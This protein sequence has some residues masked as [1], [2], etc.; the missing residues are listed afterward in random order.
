MRNNF[1]ITQHGLRMAVWNLYLLVK[2]IS[3]LY[4]YEWKE[5]SVYRTEVPYVLAIFLEDSANRRPF[6]IDYFVKD[7]VLI[8]MSEVS[9]TH[10]FAVGR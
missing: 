7:S 6:R 8:P 1:Q 10:P 5:T 3:I 4:S 9:I 2:N